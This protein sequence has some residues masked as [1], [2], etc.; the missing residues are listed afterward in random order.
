[1]LQRDGHCP[2]E[3]PI[4]FEQK[5]KVRKAHWRVQEDFARPTLKIEWN[6][7]LFPE[8]QKIRRNKKRCNEKEK[9]KN[10]Q[11][12]TEKELSVSNCATTWSAD[13]SANR[14]SLSFAETRQNNENNTRKEAKRSFM[15]TSYSFAQN[16][17]QEN[18]LCPRRKL[19]VS[20]DICDQLS[21]QNILLRRK[22]EFSDQTL[23]P[24]VARIISD[25]ASANFLF[26]LLWPLCHFS[27]HSFYLPSFLLRFDSFLRFFSFCKLHGSQRQFSSSSSIA[28]SE[29]LCSST[30]WEDSWAGSD[31]TW[32]VSGRFWSL[33]AF[34]LCFFGMAPAC[35]SCLDS[36]MLRAKTQLSLR[37]LELER[38]LI[39]LRQQGALPAD[40]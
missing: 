17:L 6:L 21:V 29:T 31:R 7:Y 12:R 24:G 9:R 20:K 40:T 13:K 2:R 22:R 19:A 4:S 38:Q 34:V 1:M 33:Y 15:K 28:R 39:A 18:R 25:L 23:L 32:C 3:Q 10:G 8:G 27:L 30:S 26:L 35:V 37:N 14:F 5:E 11:L 36:S 16:G